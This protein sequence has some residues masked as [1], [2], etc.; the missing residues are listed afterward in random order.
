MSEQRDAAAIVTQWGEAFRPLALDPRFIFEGDE[1]FVQLWKPLLKDG[2]RIERL[3]V[4]EPTLAQMRKLDG[5]HG[6]IAKVNVLLMQVCGLTEREAGAIGMR[7]L[8]QMGRLLEAFSASAR[9][10]GA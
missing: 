2:E 1:I 5:A 4:A 8:G 3:Q 9:A 10:T 6:E 7:D